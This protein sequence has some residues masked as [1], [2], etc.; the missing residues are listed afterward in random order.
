MIK[1]H[2]MNKSEWSVLGL[3]SPMDIDS[4]YVPSKDGELGWRVLDGVEQLHTGLDV[5]SL[6]N[7]SVKSMGNGLVIEVNEDN[8]SGKYIVI[9]HW[10]EDRIIDISYCHL[11]TQFMKKDEYVSQGER[12]AVLGNTGNSNGSHL[13]ISFYEYRKDL[14]RSVLIN[15]V[16]SSTYEKPIINGYYW[17]GKEI[18]YL[19]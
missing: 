19:K 6:T 9:R 16:T 18:I 7:N 8:Y 2:G 4:S 12:I 10:I 1:I 15:P 5:I 11:F 3:K 17:Q 14:Q 13:H